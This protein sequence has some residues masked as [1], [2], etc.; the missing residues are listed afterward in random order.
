ML[1]EDAWEEIRSALASMK[2]FCAPQVSAYALMTI[3]KQHDNQQNG[4]DDERAKQER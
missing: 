3:L 2:P 4:V 1:P